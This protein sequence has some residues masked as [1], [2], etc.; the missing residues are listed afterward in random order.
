VSVDPLVDETGQ[1]YAYTGDDPVNGKDPSGRDTLGFC[2]AASVQVALIGGSFDEC[3]T[4]T[5]DASGEDDIGLVGTVGGSVGVGADASLGGAIQVT[6]ANSLQQLSGLFY[7]TTVGGEVGGGGNV[8]VSWNP[9]GTVVGIEIGLAAGLGVSGGIGASDTW[10]NQLNGI[11]SA[12][13]GRGIWDLLGGVGDLSLQGLIHEAQ[14][15]AQ[16]KSQS[17][18]C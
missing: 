1:P 18:N 6:N 10:V 7:Y 16:S 2:G 4:R 12:N 3:L 14:E 17:K 5:I 11:L 9:S 15:I 8:I 13:I